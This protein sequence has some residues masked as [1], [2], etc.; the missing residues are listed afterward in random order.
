[1]KCI[2]NQ[3]QNVIIRIQDLIPRRVFK[4]YSDWLK[5]LTFVLA[6]APSSTE[7][8]E[9]LDQWGE[10]QP[11]CE[12][13][14]NSCTYISTSGPVNNWATH[15]CSYPEMFGCEVEERDDRLK[16]KTH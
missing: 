16:L 2:P 7:C 5:R 11:Q 9:K 15:Y 12:E 1:M 14:F 3:I 4:L 13:D 8:L 6:L 10:G